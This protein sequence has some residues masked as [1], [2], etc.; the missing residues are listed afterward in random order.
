MPVRKRRHHRP[1]V[2]GSDPVAAPRSGRPCLVLTG[3]PNVGKST[4]FNRIVGQSRAVVERTPGVTRDR[5][6][7][8]AEW[9]G[10]DIVVTDTGG[11]G[12]GDGDPFAPEVAAQARQALSEADV[13]LFVVD[14]GTGLLPA[15]AEIAD[16]LR[17]LRK[18][19][20][21]VANKADRAKAGVEEFFALGLGEPVGVSAVRGEGLGDVLDRAL[22]RVNRPQEQPAPE[23]AGAS[24][25]VSVALV[26]R[27]NV[28]KSSLVNRLLGEQRLIVSEI[29]GTTRDTVDVPVELAGRAFVFVDTP[30]LRRPA[31]IAPRSLERASAQ[32]STRAIARAEVVCVV[33]DA[34]EPCTDQDKRIAGLAVDNHRAAVVLLNKSDLLAPADLRAAVDGVRRELPF[35]SFAAVLPCSART[36]AGLASLPAALASAADAYRRRLPTAPLNQCIRQAIAVHPP[37]AFEGKPVRIFY[38]TQLRVQ[39]PTIVLMTN[40]QGAVASAYARYLENRLRE[41]FDLMGTP[42][43]WLFRARQ[44]R[45]L[46]LG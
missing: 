29:A 6:Y 7:A 31:R 35:L 9:A 3:R 28:G 23:P 36:S 33:L 8:A 18:P 21:L 11:L 40:R 41:R 37:A 45:R 34:G 17:R 1:G 15:D 42:V 16:T 38:A 2:P 4:I 19:V 20:V 25:P 10:C 44:H 5:L 22:A 32:R 27:P 26:G 39:P 13:V 30:G 43:R 12:G 24:P 14:A 46:I